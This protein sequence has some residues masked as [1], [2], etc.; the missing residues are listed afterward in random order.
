[1]SDGYFF[2]ITALY[3]AG[4]VLEEQSLFRPKAST[5]QQGKAKR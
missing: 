2:P 4:I 1:M 3:T 5:F